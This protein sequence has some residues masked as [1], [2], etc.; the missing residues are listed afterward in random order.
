MTYQSNAVP[1]GPAY[2]SAVN[3]ILAT[4]STTNMQSNLN[5]LAAFNNR[6]Y[7][8]A[9]GASAS[10]WIKDRIAGVSCVYKCS[11]ATSIANMTI[12]VYR[13]LFTTRRDR[14]P[15]RP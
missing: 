7:K 14:Q 8:A 9:T 5:T 15:L 1:T 11:N 6:Y 3:P 12:S 10:T 4:V 2:Q 13:Y